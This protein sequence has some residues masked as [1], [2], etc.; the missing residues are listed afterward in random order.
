M[1]MALHGNW[2]GVTAPERVMMAEALSA[3]FGRAHLL[4]RRVMAL[5]SG[6]ELARADQW[7]LAMRLG[8][9]LS[10]GVGAVLERA[11]L[12]CDERTVTLC[13]PK[14]QEALLAEP[15]WRRLERLAL[16]MGRAPAVDVSDS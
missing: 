10:G 8:Q 9:R 16:A 12:K 14:N 1:E 13:L 11:A 4:D 2:V 7:G 15:V 5:C 3:N 6:R